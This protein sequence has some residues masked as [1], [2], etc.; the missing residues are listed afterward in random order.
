MHDLKTMMPHSKAGRYWRYVVF[1]H[2]FLLVKEG[3]QY[4]HLKT[5]PV[6]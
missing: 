6:V 2:Y 5:F 3:T 1:L 4:L